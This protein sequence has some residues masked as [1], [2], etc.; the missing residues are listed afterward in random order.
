M[1]GPA[2]DS[3]DAVSVFCMLDRAGLVNVLPATLIFD[4]QGEVI[5]KVQGQARE[6]DIVGPLEWL[7]GGRVTTPSAKA[8]GFSQHARLYS[9]HVELRRLS[10]SLRIT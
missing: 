10:P 8:K 1:C 9:G 3:A 6:E 2:T 4:E 5:A 7:L